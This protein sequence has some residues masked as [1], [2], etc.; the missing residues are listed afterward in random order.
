MRVVFEFVRT[1]CK[2]VNGNE[3]L[4]LSKPLLVGQYVY[5]VN[6][7]LDNEFSRPSNY[8]DDRLMELDPEEYVAG[9]SWLSATTVAQSVSASLPTERIWLD[10][11]RA[12]V[13]EVAI[14]GLARWEYCKDTYV[15]NVISNFDAF[16]DHVTDAVVR[17]GLLPEVVRRKSVGQ[18]R[19]A[20]SKCHDLLQSRVT[21]FRIMTTRERIPDAMQFRI[22]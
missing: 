14:S 8:I 18:L 2:D 12:R 13:L 11:Y 22:L 19:S 20:R 7:F 3:I 16:S 15:P 9:V 4:L 1:E 21:T 5:I 6:N 10:C 17:K